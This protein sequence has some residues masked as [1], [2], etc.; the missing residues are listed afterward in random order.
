MESCSV[1]NVYREDSVADVVLDDGVGEN[2]HY[3]PDDDLRIN[4]YY[5]TLDHL[6]EQLDERFPAA[7]TDFAFCSLCI[8]KHLMQ[9]SAFVDLLIDISWTPNVLLVNGV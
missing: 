9:N 1:S 8:C 3:E 7:L 5:N 4:F 6:I 2:K